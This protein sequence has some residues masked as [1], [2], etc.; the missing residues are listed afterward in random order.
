ME[1]LLLSTLGGLGVLAYARREREKG[2]TPINHSVSTL[3]PKP[4]IRIIVPS[5][6]SGTDFDAQ[7]YQKL[8]KATVIYVDIESAK[9]FPLVGEYY[10]VNFWIE[11]I[12]SPELFPCRTTWM[13]INQ[14][15]L[16]VDEPL[17]RVDLFICKTR[18][19]E[20]LIRRYSTLHL[21]KAKALY[22]S[23]TSKDLF[24]NEAKN[25]K[26]AVHMA[27]KSWL[28]GTYKLV[29]AWMAADPPAR[30]I[31]TCRDFCMDNNK[32]K[33]HLGYFFKT[34]PSGEEVYETARTKITLVKFLPPEDLKQLQSRAG[35]WL[36]PS[37]VEGYGH[38]INEGRGAGAV[39]VTT[40]FPPM[41]EMVSEENGFLIDIDRTT[42][43]IQEGTLPGSLRVSPKTRNIVRALARVFS[44]SEDQL[45]HKGRKSRE[46]Y[47]RDR[48]YLEKKCNELL[49]KNSKR[50]RK[51]EKSSR[52]LIFSHQSKMSDREQPS[53]S[54]VQTAKMNSPPPRSQESLPPRI[55][56]PAYVGL[57]NIPR[58][59]KPLVCSGY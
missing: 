7:V 6:S 56:G 27:G 58:D 39:V 53:V 14:E 33:Q 52:L 19:A 24:S 50:S 12:F 55:Q 48:K 46:F 21:P 28:K 47:L 34:L 32:L 10:E 2:V 31:V 41:N 16:R 54:Q 25:Y 36:C 11:R 43:I 26:L 22:A 59:M 3:H 29:K 42:K 5:G 9:T 57:R 18:Y 35:I 51:I 37:E 44:S 17:G 49:E 4:K 30:L 20:N 8:L 13:M 38:Y 1:A 40:D 23:H 45:V 15:M